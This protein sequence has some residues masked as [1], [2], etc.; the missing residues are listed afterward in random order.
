MAQA[1]GAMAIKSCC[2]SDDW[3]MTSKPESTGM[4]KGSACI[5]S[6]IVHCQNISYDQPEHE[7]NGDGD[8]TQWEQEGGNSYWIMI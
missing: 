4:F 3:S 5:N 8:C 1:E 2:H 6:L 7:W